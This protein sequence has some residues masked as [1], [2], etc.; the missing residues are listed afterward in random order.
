MDRLFRDGISPLANATL[1]ER[2]KQIEASSVRKYFEMAEVTDQDKDKSFD[3]VV[4]KFGLPR[5]EILIAYDRIVRGIR[6]GNKN[7][8]PTVWFQNGKFANE[9]P[10]QIVAQGNRLSL[11]N[12]YQ[13]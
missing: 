5:N 2:K 7:G 3:F 4:A 11:L 8:H 13:N 9:L 10:G 1:E 6:Y 12:H